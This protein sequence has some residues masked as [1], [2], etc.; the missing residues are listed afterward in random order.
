[1]DMTRLAREF[2]DAGSGVIVFAS[3]QGK[4]YS[5]EHPDWRHGAFTKAILDGLT[6]KADF[7]QDGVVHHS[8]LEVFVKRGVVDLTEGRQHPVTIR[9]DAIAD[10]A[11][12]VV[13]KG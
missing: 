13:Q 1:M 12:A 9:P 2:S 11:L 7:V 8:E 4:E 6:G 5:E 10:F 3:S